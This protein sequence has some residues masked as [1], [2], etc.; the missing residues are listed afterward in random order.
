MKKL[1]LV[2][3]F[4]INVEIKSSIHRLQIIYFILGIINAFKE[5][6]IASLIGVESGHAISSSLGVLRQ[7][8]QLGV[9]YMTLTHSCNTPW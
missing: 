6:K 5:K 7:F 1:I 3:L 9:R 4:L 2:F 8:Y